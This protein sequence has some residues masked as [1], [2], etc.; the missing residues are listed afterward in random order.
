MNILGK[1][2]TLENLTPN[3]QT[4][5][6]FILE[7]TKMVLDYSPKELSEASFVS[8]ATVYRLLKKIDQPGFNEFKVS[9]ASSVRLMSTNDDI[10]I[11][12]PISKTQSTEELINSMENLYHNTLNETIKLAD[13]TVV[14]D[15]VDL[16][17]QAKQVDVYASAGNIHFAKN[18]Q[19][20]LQEIGHCIHVPD[21][22]YLQR[23]FA[24][25][26]TNEHVAIVVSYGGRGHTT[27]AVVD[28]LT[29]NQTPIIL[30]TST[31]QN[32]LSDRADLSLY[33][34]STENHY[35]KVSSF[36]TRFS[37]LVVFDLLYAELFNRDFE[38]NR[39]YK[40]NN[41]KKMNKELK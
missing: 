22:D 12:Y 4:L 25:N 26:S 33:L 7:N 23:L 2:S 3:E 1:L 36:S 28:I 9:L 39:Q 5:V 41:Y 29:A 21:E 14:R 31:Q 32:N 27:N 34:S 16:L 19:F 8:I 10:N 18:F 40:L 24:S 35:N 30:I 37:L 38:S 6:Q 17:L 20:Q 15:A 11:N 13:S